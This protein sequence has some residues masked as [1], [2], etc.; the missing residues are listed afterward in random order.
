MK[1]YLYSSATIPLEPGEF[2][3]AVYR[4]AKCPGK[5]AVVI[6]QGDPTEQP[7]F[8]RIHSECFTGEVLGSLKCDC[9]DQLHAALVRIASDNHGMVIYLRQE[10]RG[11][12]LGNKIRAYHLQ[13]QGLNTLQA[14]HALG[15]PDDARTFEQAT[16]I[17]QE[18]GIETILLN[19]N[20][21]QKIKEVEDAG[22]TVQ[23]VIPA[24]SP[25]NHHNRSYLLTKYK[26]MG[27]RLSALFK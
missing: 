24:L 10:G 4:F 9:R 21:P 7:P 5:E 8:V 23:D 2:D 27:H 17:L 1:A 12:G 18:L 26:D 11:I 20:N 15:F 22:I 14:N 3:I 6:S 13:N 25:V 16:A 19:T